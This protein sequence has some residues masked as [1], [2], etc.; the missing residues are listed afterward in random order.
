MNA[1]PV[2][3]EALLISLGDT[4]DIDAARKLDMPAYRL[5][6]KARLRLGQDLPVVSAHG[7]GYSLATLVEVL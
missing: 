5:R 7:D 2:Q 1:H 3:R 4:N 6:R